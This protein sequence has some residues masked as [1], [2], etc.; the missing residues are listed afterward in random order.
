MVKLSLDRCKIGE[1]VGM[2]KLYVVENSDSRP[3]MHHLGSLIEEGGIV[4]ISL[5]HEMALL[6]Q[7]CRYPKIDWNT[8]DE[9]TGLQSGVL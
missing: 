3:V 5:D 2:I 1:D 4:F 9:K 7:P 6:S 8:S